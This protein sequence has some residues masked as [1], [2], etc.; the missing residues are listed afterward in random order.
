MDKDTCD[1]Y[2]QDETKR[3]SR[4]NSLGLSLVSS[5]NPGSL[6]D[7]PN[8][9]EKT[10]VGEVK[11]ENMMTANAWRWNPEVYSIPDKATLHIH[12]ANGN[13]IWMVVR[14]AQRSRGF[15]PR[16]LAFLTKTT[17]PTIAA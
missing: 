14:G 11:S 2:V 10:V 4:G 15:V 8:Y 9:D 16:A 7:T 5:G 1:I 6:R 13:D 17:T 3:D 12:L